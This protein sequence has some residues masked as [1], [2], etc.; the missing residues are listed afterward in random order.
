MGWWWGRLEWVYLL[1]M[2]LLRTVK[3]RHFGVDR[4][5]DKVLET[6]WFDL[7][8]VNVDTSSWFNLILHR[9]SKCIL[10]HSSSIFSGGMFEGRWYLVYPEEGA[11]KSRQHSVHILC[12]RISNLRIKV[13]MSDKFCVYFMPNPG[14]YFSK[15]YEGKK[16]CVVWHSFR[17]WS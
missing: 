5:F 1:K 12:R 13:Y 11:G 6:L 7:G 16:I 15:I 17:D 2:T 9:E 8:F 14:D 10:M 3:C 4:V